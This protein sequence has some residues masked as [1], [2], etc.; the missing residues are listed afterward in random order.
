MTDAGHTSKHWSA[1]PWLTVEEAAHRLGVSRSFIKQR[2]AANEIPHRHLGRAVRLRV[3]EL[4]SWADGK[5]GVRL[6][7]SA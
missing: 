7:L 3:D 6:E 1:S 5:P 2:V 4:D